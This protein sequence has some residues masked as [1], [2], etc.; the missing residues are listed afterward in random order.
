MK[1]STILNHLRR[2]MPG[3]TWTPPDDSETW[4]IQYCVDED[5]KKREKY[6]RIGRLRMD[7]RL[8]V[9]CLASASPTD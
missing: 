1:S 2:L 9:C 8:V 6:G 5:N 7:G 4:A 3:D